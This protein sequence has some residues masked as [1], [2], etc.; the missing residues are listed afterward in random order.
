M[1]LIDSTVPPRGYSV[2]VR[3]SCN[4]NLAATS[5]RCD[6][7]IDISCASSD[8]AGVHIRTWDKVCCKR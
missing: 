7:P 6:L 2:T 5:L 1:R 8:A 4:L 3:G